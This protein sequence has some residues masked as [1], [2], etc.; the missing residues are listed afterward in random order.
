MTRSINAYIILSFLIF[1]NNSCV[2]D[3]GQSNGV[4]TFISSQSYGCIQ[5]IPFDQISDEGVLTW[6]WERGTLGLFVH[7]DTH[8]ETNMIDSVNVKEDLITIM[9][10][11]T[12]SVE[13][14][15]ACKFRETYYFRVDAF[16]EVKVKCL[17]KSIRSESFLLVIDRTLIL[18][19]ENTGF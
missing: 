14:N 8:C 9:L 12:A 1:F 16:N 11:D 5:E 15:C 18:E 19:V 17:F 7:V 10:E 3:P 4:I 2:E 6:Q 13:S